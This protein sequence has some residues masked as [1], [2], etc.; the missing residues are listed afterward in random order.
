MTPH[1]EDNVTIEW[2]YQKGIEN[3]RGGVWCQIEI[4]DQ[5]NTIQRLIRNY[6]GVCFQCG[7]E[8]HLG[9]DCH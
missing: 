3:V 8:G 5:V 1:D 2:M 6:V 9:R 7:K 4:Q